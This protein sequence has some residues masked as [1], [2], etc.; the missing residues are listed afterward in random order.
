MLSAVRFKGF[1]APSL[2]LHP[3][4]DLVRYRAAARFLRATKVCGLMAIALCL[5]LSCSLTA[6]AQVDTG[7]L[8][9]T[10]TDTSGARIPHAQVTIRN[11]ATG[12]QLQ[13]PTRGD[14]S[15]SFT[16][17]KVGSYTV[18][19]TAP[20]FDKV[21]QTH[22]PLT[23]EQQLELNMTL[24]PGEVSATAEVNADEAALQTQE[25]S[26]G[27]VVTAD[28][29]NNLPLNGRNFTL[30]AQLAP[31]TTTTYYDSGHGEVQSGTFVANGVVTT[32]NDYLLDGITN[33]NM[34]S[35]FGNGNSFTLL[36]PPDALQEFKVETG[37]Y[38]AEYGRSG[39]AVINAVTRSG[40]NRIFGDIW[41][42]NRNAYF[43]A[44]DYFLKKGGLKRPQ[45]NRNQFGGSIGGPV[46]IPHL[47]NGHDR[48][49]FFADY[50]GLRLVQGGAY[51]SSVPTL[52]EQ[53]SKFTDFTDQYSTGTQTDIL[54][55]VFQAG[56]IFDPATTRY[57]PTGFVD[58]VTGIK[59]TKSGYLRD[60]FTTNGSVPG[61]GT[62]TTCT[63]VLP[64]TRVSPVS[65]GLLALF[66][67]PNTNGTKFSNNYV[68][69]P[70]LY[71][72]SD[73]YDSRVDENISSKDQLFERASGG[74]IPSTIPAPC[75]TLA[76]CGV[77]AT[78][79]TRTNKIFGAAIGETHIFS[80]RLVNEL[81]I[82]YNRIHTDT[83]EPYG[84]T[85]GLNAKYGI[86]GIP[87]GPGNGG[88]A[89]IKITGLSELGEHNNVPLNEI[90]AETQYNENMSLDIGHHSMRFGADYE[91]MKN[92]I[93]SAQFPHGYFSYTGSFVD[94]PNG[95]AYNL[96]LVQFAIEPT[97]S[98]VSGVCPNNLEATGGTSTGCGYYNYI[99]GTNQI[100]G[101]PLSQQDYRRPYFGTYFTDTWRVTSKFTATLGLRWEYFEQGIDHYGH[102]SNFVPGFLAPGGQAE[103]LIDDRAK[104]IPLAPSFVSLLSASGINLVYTSNHQL[105]VMPKKNFSP[106]VGFAWNFSPNS[107]LRAAYGIF[108]AGIYARGDGYNPGDDYPFSFAINITPGLSS[109]SLASDSAYGNGG[110][111]GTPT[112][113][114]M[115]EG[116]AGVP[117]TPLGAQGYQISPRGNQYF[118]HVPYVQEE[119]LT[120]QQLLSA[121]Q[122]LQIA[123]VGTQSRHVEST[124][125]NN[126]ADLMLP[127]NISVTPISPS[128]TCQSK[129]PGMT[130]DG[131][132]GTD[133][134][135]TT[136]YY[137]Q[138]PCIAQNNYENVLEGS[139]NYNS[140]QVSYRKFLGGNGSS[141]IAN[142]TWDKLMGYGADSSLFYSPGYRA[143]LVPGFGM[144]G[145]YG[146]LDFGSSN[147]FHAGGIWKIPVGYGR[148]FLSH[149]GVLDALIGGWNATGIVTYQGGQPVTLTC[150]VTETNTGGCYSIPD[151]SL[152][153]SGA[154]TVAHWFNA[155]AWSNPAVAAATIGQTD[156]SPLGSKPEQGFGPA[157]H[158]GDL[159]VEKLF[160]LPG[161]NVFEFRAES[162]NITNHPNFGQPGT[163]TFN[164]AAFAS[165]TSTRDSPSD[166]REMQ[167]ALKYFF[168]SG[169]QY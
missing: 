147:I 22:V 28:E 1:D 60:P 83:V 141:L 52:A 49:F 10:V 138:Y 132:V 122:T 135:V 48:T 12:L 64:A 134:E 61:P 70:K 9:G 15:Y 93:N 101:S 37:N 55:R 106:R 33:N 119:N 54:G 104:N 108:Y 85:G 117:L 94:N 149:K 79:G 133:V 90:G 76:D 53:S 77:S 27:Q 69:A 7:S 44:E 67:L 89:Q 103:Y 29:I 165:I 129:L 137:D 116:L 140:L 56:Q 26:V 143:P 23:V 130:H 25:A 20:G 13:Q 127:T 4:R 59:T 125:G 84:E 73:T 128:A 110:T 38:S 68:S 124:I 78:M 43:D 109:S 111:N 131:G 153:Y 156:F 123:Y 98:S 145:D 113:G 154:K 50:S 126:R 92:A 151:K 6:G 42:Y 162:F 112:Y 121:S 35:D 158:R 31:G 39:G 157:F 18:T 14:G 120:L 148:H 87:D 164:N 136:N 118:T 100:Q 105:A 40:Q 169:G 17:V 155:A 88:L 97:V 8:L 96:G 107:V 99:G 2:Q 82:G 46:T 63:N 150:S 47:Y 65:A 5:L 71:Q 159:G 3:D 36:P 21:E 115:D 81:R 51:T 30:L 58:P 19:A 57:L 161:A 91:R 16:A 80:P 160:H 95:S 72:T 163:L 114:P 32:F 66:P 152:E 142:Y 86:P 74:N 45:F 62:C 144:P 102:G 168:G 166:A 139:D 34:S 167:F 24:K 11:E 75:P 41:E 146:N